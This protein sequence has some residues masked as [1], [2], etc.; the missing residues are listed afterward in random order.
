MRIFDF[1]PGENNELDGFYSDR[2]VGGTSCFMEY[3]GKKES[4]DTAFLRHH[5]QYGGFDVGACAILDTDPGMVD[6]VAIL[7]ISGGV[8]FQ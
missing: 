6:A 7:G 4:Y 8:G 2:D 3:S 1:T 5:L